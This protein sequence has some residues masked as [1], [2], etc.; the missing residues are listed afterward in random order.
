MA[1]MKKDQKEKE[2]EEEGEGEDGELSSLTSL[3]A[4]GRIQKQY[5]TVQ[6]FFILFFA[7]QIFFFL[8]PTYF[9]DREA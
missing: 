6:S 9:T 4:K 2:E 5:C 8:A 7:F 1:K 3:M